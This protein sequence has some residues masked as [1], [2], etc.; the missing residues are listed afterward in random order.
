M[1]IPVNN[2]REEH[3]KEERNSILPFGGIHA[4]LVD[5]LQ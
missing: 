5:R 2:R 4:G 1:L 3:E